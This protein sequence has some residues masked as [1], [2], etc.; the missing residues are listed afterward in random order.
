MT[1]YLKTDPI[2]YNTQVYFRKYIL[3]RLPNDDKVWARVYRQ[4]LKKQ[5]CS[6]EKCKENIIRN[7]LDIAP[8]WDSYKFEN[9]QDAFV[10]MLRWS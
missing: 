5:G 10:F 2:Y 1:Y 8:G 6:I 4:W 3:D 9:S 7:G